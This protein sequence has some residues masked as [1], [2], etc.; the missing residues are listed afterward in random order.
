MTFPKA[1]EDN[2]QVIN[3]NNE[4]AIRGFVKQTQNLIPLFE[5]IKYLYYECTRDGIKKDKEQDALNKKFLSI[6]AMFNKFSGFSY[7][8]E[9]QKLKTEL[10]KSQK[11]WFEMLNLFNPICFFGNK[12]DD[13]VSELEKSIQNS[14]DN[15]NFQSNAQAELD[16]FKYF[17]KQI[18]IDFSPDKEV[19]PFPSI[20]P[21]VPYYIDND[22]NNNEY[23]TTAIAKSQDLTEQFQKF[24]D[25]CF[26]LRTL[27]LSFER[28]HVEIENIK[29]NK[30]LHIHAIEYCTE[31]INHQESNKA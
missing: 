28:I 16:R 11:E 17:K 13:V 26:L 18:D 1:M 9:I 29:S 22:R 8:T 31:V 7:E 14:T 2:S 10:D 20:S 6:E 30:P 21:I 4:E 15:K 19:K 24:K 27:S 3:V 5:E 12:I 25:L 23:F